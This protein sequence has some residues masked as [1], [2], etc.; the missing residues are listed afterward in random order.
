VTFHLQPCFAYLEQREGAF[1]HAEAAAKEALALPIY[2]EHSDA[3]QSQVVDEIA[4][5]YDLSHGSAAAAVPPRP[6]VLRSA[7]AS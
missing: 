3:Q 1:P 2:A 5:L 6:G 4:Q 7:C